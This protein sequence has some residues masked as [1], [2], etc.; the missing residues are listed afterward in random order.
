MP[1]PQVIPDK[2]GMLSIRITPE[3]RSLIDRAAKMQGKSRADFVLDA[4]RAAADEAQLG[5]AVTTAGSEAYMAFLARLDMPA[6]PNERLRRTMRTKV[7]WDK[8]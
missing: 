4:A 1:A 7:P 6:Q 3:E 5:Q 8:V 2:R